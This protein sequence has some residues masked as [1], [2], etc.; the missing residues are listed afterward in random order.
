[1]LKVEYIS[2]NQINHSIDWIICERKE[3]HMKEVKIFIEDNG[4]REYEDTDILLRQ[5]TEE[6]DIPRKVVLQLVDIEGQIITGRCNLVVGTLESGDFL[7]TGNV[8]EVLFEK[9]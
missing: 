8:E 6:Y 9:K 3:I 2:N 4:Y 5:L 1:M 7:L